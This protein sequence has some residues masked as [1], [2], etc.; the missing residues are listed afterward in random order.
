[1]PSDPIV[2]LVAEP[3]PEVIV[4][5]FAAPGPPGPP[6]EAGAT[7]P[8][9]I[10]G[11][12][13][14]PGPEGPPGATG[15]QGSTGPA[16]PQGPQGIKGDTGLTGATGPAGATG[17]QGAAG[18]QGPKG[19]TGL[20]GATGPAGPQGAQGIQGPAGPTGAT[21]PQGPQGLKGDTG[22]T[23]ATGPA[24]PTGPQG[25]KGDTGLTG[26]TG[27]AGPI[28]PAGA[29]GPQGLQGPKGDTGSTGAPGAAATISIGTVSTGS[30]GTAA[31]VS[32]SGT[33]SNAILNFVIPRGADGTPGTGSGTGGTRTFMRFG[34]RENEPPATSFAV[35]DTRD[36]LPVLAFPWD[37]QASAIF[38]ETIPQGTDISGGI[39]F[40]IQW[41][42]LSSISGTVG[43]TV[44][45]QRLSDDGIDTDSASSQFGTPAVITEV[46]V[47][48]AAGQLRTT[49][50]QIGALGLPTGLTA[51]NGLRIRLRRNIAA[52][53]S[54]SSAQFI[55][56][57]AESI[58]ATP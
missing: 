19:D 31:S 16:G 40:F 45:L 14:P 24:G 6:G 46:T 42:S 17:P 21:G 36:G 49:S 13:G 10:V 39:A 34:P 15:P 2:I 52:D 43:W 56:G 44:E 47:P 27:P 33:S 25:I 26:A 8:P 58:P 11:P 50:V 54:T 20:T 38:T 32:N 30:P 51:G 1:M 7:G 29:T 55:R 28:G 41:A 4:A 35:I 5:E 57:W 22:L 48:A 37:V 3:G 18:P 23:G 53:D 12:M 9:G